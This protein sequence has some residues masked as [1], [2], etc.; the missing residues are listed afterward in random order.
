MAERIRVYI[1]AGG[2]RTFASAA[3]WPG[4]SR[5]GKD[6]KS[7]LENLAAYAPRYARVAKLARVQFPQDEPSFNVIERLTGNATTDFGAP[8]IPAKNESKP[9]TDHEAQRVVALL[10]A[11]WKYLDNVRAKAPEELR[12]GP[13]GGGR[14]REKMYRHVLDAEVAYAPAIGLKLKQPDRKALLEAIRK[15]NKDTKWPVAYA[16][17]R[18][19]WH[20]LDHA[21]EM[22]DRIP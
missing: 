3:D 10:E 2:K 16:V 20:A 21:W 1:E 4:W 6:E 17:R 15:P 8:G 14:D 11:S 18:I 12:K 5:S 13:R 7:A 19:A 9:M 22:E